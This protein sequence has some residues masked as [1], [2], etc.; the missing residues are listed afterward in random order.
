MT[1]A[2]PVR[3]TH[4]IVDCH[5]QLLDANVR[6][7]LGVP[8][9]DAPRDRSEAAWHLEAVTTVDHAFVL[10]LKSGFLSIDVPN[11]VIAEHVGRAA[12]KLI[13]FAGIDPC[14]SDWR[15]ELSI[16]H[17]ELGLRGV[18]LCP[19]IQNFHPTDT[20]AMELY[21]ECARRRLPIVFDSCPHSP[22]ARLEYARPL[23]LDEVARSLP[24]LRMVVSHVGYPWSEE[25][26]TIIA[27][28]ANVYA[29]IGG[30]LRRPW[31][32][33]TTM[34]S[35]MEMGALS[36]LLFGSDFPRRSPAAAIE[37][38]Y[39]INRFAQDSN[40]PTIP[41]EQLRGVVERDA[42]ALLGIERPAGASGGSSRTASDDE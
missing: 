29:S 38:L 28:H 18:T 19:A 11:R 36:K 42:L 16:A 37:T 5:T 3:P 32:C 14:D 9:A 26:L 39:S 23:L 20:R 27:K 30:L 22:S 13:G 33:Y 35:A 10:G 6:T 2:R 41:R 34:L 12:S 8:T 21:E 1:P 15:R 24:E 17:Q 25:T 31:L 7:R 4:M 40:L